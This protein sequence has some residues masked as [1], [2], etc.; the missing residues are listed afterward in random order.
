[1]STAG[2]LYLIPTTL[3][4]DA[5]FSL[6]EYVKESIRPLKVFFVENE[7]SARRFIKSIDRNI[8]V[9][10]M[11][12][13]PM[14]EHQPPDV[15]LAKRLL[16]EG[17][18]VGVISEAGCPAVA[19][20]GQVVVRA[21][22]EV[23][24]QVIPMVGPNSM[25]LALMASG[26]NGQYFQFLGYLPVKGPERVKAIRELEAVSQ[27]KGQTQICIEAPYRNMQLFADVLANC[28]DDT[29]FCVAADLTAPTEYIRTQRIG[30]WKKQPAPELHKR[31]A[32]FLLA[33]F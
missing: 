1:M 18:A 10:V 4:A 7:R 3:S 12:L 17:Q 2:R 13:L 8:D 24:A 19:D 25:L 20:P 15:A 27:K 5:L 33:G 14:N 22:H 31:P 6:P 23:G 9:D 11:Q 21:A 16:K 26:M 29:L 30:E 32:I 28:K